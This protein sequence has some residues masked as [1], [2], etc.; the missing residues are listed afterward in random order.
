[1]RRGVWSRVVAYTRLCCL[2]AY[3]RL[4]TPGCMDP[5]GGMEPRGRLQSPGGCL[6]RMDAWV[7]DEPVD[8]WW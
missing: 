4:Q 8:W 1:M 3:G 5:R 2:V 7:L 6:D